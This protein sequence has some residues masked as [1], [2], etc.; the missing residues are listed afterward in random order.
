MSKINPLMD[1]S[2]CTFRIENSRDKTARIQI[3]RDL[4]INWVYTYECSFYG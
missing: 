1:Y 4:K 2:S 3:W